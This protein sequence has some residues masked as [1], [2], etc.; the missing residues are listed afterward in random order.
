VIDSI[1]ASE[2]PS[3]TIRPKVF[4]GSSSEGKEFA[5]AAR[6]LLEPGIEVTLWDEDFADLGRVCEAYSARA[7]LDTTGTVERVSL[8][9]PA[10]EK[11]RAVKRRHQPDRLLV[12]H[13]R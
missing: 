11:A 1:A 3:R 13:R 8:S 4:I 5:H 6:G 2:T 12:T 10:G 9:D 7:R